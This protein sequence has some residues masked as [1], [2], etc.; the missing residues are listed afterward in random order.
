[1]GIMDRTFEE[2]IP[3]H[4]LKKTLLQIVLIP[5]SEDAVRYIINFLLHIIPLKLPFEVETVDAYRPAIVIKE[6]LILLLALVFFQIFWSCFTECHCPVSFYS[7][8]KSNI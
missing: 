6:Q 4:T 5:E 1:M 2:Q 7:F 8:P 3:F